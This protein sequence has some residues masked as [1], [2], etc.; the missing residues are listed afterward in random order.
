MDLLG[1]GS[2]ISQAEFNPL[3]S[4]ARDALKR[5]RLFHQIVASHSGRYFPTLVMN[6]GAAA[7]R[8]LSFRNRSVTHD[9]LVRAWNLFKQIRSEET[10]QGF[11][12]VRAVL[13]CG[14]RMRGSRAGLDATNTQFQ[15]VMKR[16]QETKISAKQAISEAA[17]IR[18][19]FDIVPQLQANF[20][21]TKAYVAETGG[22]ALGLNRPRF[23]VDLTLF[24]TP[25]PPWLELGP[26]IEWSHPSLSLRTSFAPILN[27]PQWKHIEGGPVG[28]LDGHQV[29][30]R[31]ANNPDVLN[32]LRSAEKP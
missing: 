11:P 8:D 15:S 32:A 17:T 29:A 18:R 28:I 19:T 30:Q 5:L 3:H 1:Y 12:G 16:F 25:P 6:D 2:M 9:F 23:F 21:F 22:S 13:A 14:F 26:R 20:A 31:L 7:Y 4:K 10:S 24:E 27:L